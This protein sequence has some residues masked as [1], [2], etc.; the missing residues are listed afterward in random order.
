ML[1]GTVLG[2]FTA[3]S[4]GGCHFSTAFLQLQHHSLLYN[5]INASIE[6]ISLGDLGGTV[7]GVQR[8]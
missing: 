3:A 8:T 5:L 6:D 4:T 2:K 1:K 7:G